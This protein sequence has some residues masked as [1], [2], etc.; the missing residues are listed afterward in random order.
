MR[1]TKQAEIVEEGKSAQ[2]YA[3]YTDQAELELGI[4]SGKEKGKG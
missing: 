1:L 3:R 4:L 2:G